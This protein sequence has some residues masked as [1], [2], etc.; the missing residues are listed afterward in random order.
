M[1]MGQIKSKNTV[2]LVLTLLVGMFFSSI[3]SAANFI[4]YPTAT[5]TD[6][7]YSLTWNTTGGTAEFHSLKVKEYLNDVFV[8][9][10][11]TTGT[12]IALI[13]RQ[14]GNYR[15][16]LQIVRR[17]WIPRDDTYYYLPA[18]VEDSIS[19]VVD[20]AVASPVID[21]SPSGISYDGSYVV[22]WNHVSFA[23]SY[24]LEE[25]IGTSAWIEIQNNGATSRSF[26][27]ISQGSYSYRVTACTNFGF[28]CSALSEI[29]TIDLA[30][31]PDFTYGSSTHNSINGDFDGNG[32]QDVFYQ[33]KNE[34]ITLGI[35][36]LNLVDTVNSNLHR[37]WTTT[38]PDFT[39]IEDWSEESYAAFSGNFNANA[40]DELLLLGRKSILL[41]HG[42]V[43]TP[44]TIFQP[45][46]NAIVSWNASNVA[47][48]TEF[49]FDAHPDNYEVI[50]GN[51]DGDEFDEIFLQ[52][53]SK[54]STSYILDSDGALIQTI[55]NGYRNMDWSAVSYSISITGGDIFLTALTS[56][57]DDNIA[58]T[59]ASGVITSLATV[60]TKPTISIT[61]NKYVFHNIA[62]NSIPTTTGSSSTFTY[63]AS[64]MPSWMSINT[65]TGELSGTPTINDVDQSH[66]IK[67]TVHENKTH[68][69]DVSMYV[70]INVVESFSISETGY[71]VYETTDGTLYLVSDNGVD[72]YKIVDD[73]G[74]D[75]V[76]K[77]S[78][79]EFNGA[80]ATLV[81]GYEVK[82]VDFNVDGRLDL[83]LTHPTDS[84]YS[85]ILI[86]D[87]YGTTHI[88]V[89][90]QF[91][92]VAPSPHVESIPAVD[93]NSQQVGAIQGNFRVDEGGAATYTIP[94]NLPTGT[95]GVTP[96]LALGYSS[97]GQN[98]IMG[99]GWTLSG[100]SSI[101]RCKKIPETDGL[102]TE[103]D[104]VSYNLTDKFC[105]DGHRLVLVSD[106]LAYG[107]NGAEYSTEI[108]S[109]QRVTSYGIAGNGP[110]YFIIESKDGAKTYYG[111]TVDSALKTNSS[112]GINDTKVSWS[113]NRS[114]DRLGNYINYVYFTDN[115]NG[116]QRIERIEYTGNETL[117]PYNFVHFDYESRDD[118]RTSYLNGSK[119][120]IDK[121]LAKIWIETPAPL[122]GIATLVKRYEFDYESNN[123]SSTNNQSLLAQIT[124]C[125]G[126]S[127]STCLQ[128]TSFD[129]EHGAN[130]F[131]G[132]TV[133]W[134]GGAFPASLDAKIK[135]VDP[136]D[137]NGDG[138]L[139]VAILYK[140]PSYGY[141]LQVGSLSEAGFNSTTWFKMP[142][143][144]G[145]LIAGH[146]GDI[147][148]DGKDDLLAPG[149]TYNEASWSYYIYNGTATGLQRGINTG[150]QYDENIKANQLMLAD[151]N[152]DALPD[153]VY[154]LSSS[155]IGIRRNLGGI[156]GIEEIK[157]LSFIN[158]DPNHELFK[159]DE[160][161]SLHD[162]QG[163]GRFDIIL[164]GRL[165]RVGW[166]IYPATCLDEA[167]NRRTIDQVFVATN[168]AE[169]NG[170]DFEFVSDLNVAFD[171]SDKTYIN[172]SGT[173]TP[174]GQGAAKFVD[175]N[176][177]GLVDI[178]HA[179][180]IHINRGDNKLTHPHSNHPDR[181]EQFTEIT[182]FNKSSM[183]DY[184][185]DGFL[186]V[187]YPDRNNS[188]HRWRVRLFDGNVFASEEITTNIYA[189][190]D[191]VDV[192]KSQHDIFSD[193]DGDSQIDRFYIAGEKVARI[194]AGE[195]I[196]AARNTITRF[197]NGM[198]NYEEVTYKP[199]TDVSVYKK[200]SG[201]KELDY[202]NGS[203]VFDLI[204]SY[205][206][207][208]EARSIAPDYLDEN[209]VVSVSY[210]YRNFRVQAGGRGSL[211]FEKIYS[212]D[213][214]TGIVTGTRYRQ[215]FPYI[216]SPAQTVIGY[217]MDAV[218]S[219]LT[220]QHLTPNEIISVTTTEWSLRQV[221]TGFTDF[222][223]LETS[224]FT[225]FIGGL[226][227][228][229]TTVLTVDDY[230]NVL[231][232][233]ESLYETRG[234]TPYFTQRKETINKY[235]ED[236]VTNWILGRLTETTVKTSRPDENQIVVPPISRTSSF[237]Y[238]SVS[239]QL[240]Y[241]I[242]N[243][244]DVENKLKLTT[245][246]TYDDFGNTLRATHC[247]GHIQPSNCGISTMQDEAD[248]YFINRYS[249]NEWDDRGR[250]VDRS[251][252]A[253][254]QK[255]TEVT[256]RHI[257]GLATQTVSLDGVVVD[258]AFDAHGRPYFERSSTGAWLLTQLGLITDSN[259]ESI[260]F[261]QTTNGAGVPQSTKQFDR[262][263][264]V[265]LEQ[266]IAFDGINVIYV[267][268]NYDSRGRLHFESVPSYNLAN[269]IGTTF[270][271]DDFGRPLSTIHPVGTSS[272][273]YGNE[274]SVTFTN[275]INQTKTEE[276]NALGE[277]IGTYENGNSNLKT[278]YGYDAVGNLTRT[279]DMD[280]VD[281]SLIDYD[282][283]GRKVEL[284]DSDM[285]I[286]IYDYNALGE[287]VEQTDAKLQITQI[288]YDQLGR[289][290]KRIETGGNP[291]ETQWFYDSYVLVD[292]P[293]KLIHEANITTGYSKTYTY[294]SF[295]RLNS[296]T[297][298]MPALG[299]VTAKSYVE[300]VTFDEY[301]RIF[302]KFDVSG[303]DA[304]LQ[305]VYDEQGY[306]ARIK[307]TRHSLDD[308]YYKINSMD[309]FGNLTELE[310]GNGITSNRDYDPATGMLD[311][312][313]T[314]DGNNIQDLGYHFDA[315][316]RLERR[317]SWTLEGGLKQE[318]FGY[319]NQ[320][321]LETAEILNSSLPILSLTY[322][323][324][325]N[326][327]TKSDVGT[328]I[329]DYSTNHSSCTFNSS[330]MH[331]VK[332][333]GTRSYCYDAN[334]NRVKTLENGSETQSVSYSNFNK[335]VSI[336][337][338]VNNHTTSFVYGV[339]RER[340]VRVDSKVSGTDTTHYVGNVEIHYKNNGQVEYKRSINGNASLS[341]IDGVSTLNY[342]FKDYQGSITAITDSQIGANAQVLQRMSFDPFG[343]R[344]VEI[345]WEQMN[346]AL[347][348]SFD[349]NITTRGYT[350]HEMLDEV[351]IIHMNGRTYD[352]EIGRFMQADPFVQDPSN[353]QN[354]NRYS[355]VLNSPMS[356]TDP[357]GY[358]Y[359]RVPV[360]PSTNYSGIL[361]QVGVAI[362]TYGASVPFQVSVAAVAGY[363]Q[364]G[365]LRGAATGAFT[366]YMMNHIGSNFSGGEKVFA[367]A[368]AGGIS[369]VLQGGKFGHGFVS[370][371]VVS[372]AHDTIKAIPSDTGQVLAAA[373]LGG[374]VSAATGGKFANGAVTSA[375]RW[376]FNE[377]AS[378]ST[379]SKSNNRPSLANL[380]A[381][382]K[383]KLDASILSVNEELKVRHHTFSSA[384]EAADF[385]HDRLGKLSDLYGVEIGANIYKGSL[386]NSAVVF[387]ATTQYYTNTVGLRARSGWSILADFHTHGSSE[388]S[389]LFS[390]FSDTDL[391][392]NIGGKYSGYLS[393]PDGN[394]YHFN[395]SALQN[396]G[397]A[398]TVS[399]ARKFVQ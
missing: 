169:P 69:L 110:N 243:P 208:A 232:I 93:I 97:A 81:A 30:Y 187:I 116:V 327:R 247:S 324:N 128:P 73:N 349:H 352:A 105:L 358:F 367:H 315:L 388:Y 144:E 75:V 342:L 61:S 80:S 250:F 53:K 285:G 158:E 231:T 199:L 137:F 299:S 29:K 9:D 337:N 271:Y 57:D 303:N 257:T 233:D 335:P 350:G 301:G 189:H 64:G 47:S 102:E 171:D 228:T 184:N 375:F 82:V 51:L 398:Q 254:E 270:S 353:G 390:G 140:R 200:G 238:D 142:S 229:K 329:Y 354:L 130:D 43:I 193:F 373:I 252:N 190:P 45:V 136:I 297:T 306:L 372:T 115:E 70:N 206:V 27:N 71:T 276:R 149:Y 214:L 202:G 368:V 267:S 334:G 153:L 341:I 173:P 109:I 377:G 274:F 289:K 147:D 58:Y 159:I 91:I 316:G 212:T 77:S 11:A 296:S 3:S 395:Y 181:I 13:N 10:V 326:I 156:F 346:E 201:A 197:N 161:S 177:D 260:G 90:D 129:W 268:R 263:G 151:V 150:I 35:L 338:T 165:C 287:L 244:D 277:L 111:N 216:G 347:L 68:T 387:N 305:Y 179:D 241:E 46:Q 223:Y 374:T 240:K 133:I 17:T 124:E 118:S 195:T 31:I 386:P 16:D 286:W 325:G 328:N 314:G 188:P 322:E 152:G 320:N 196:L 141:A 63:S 369:S 32:D 59:N 48:H 279:T 365:T 2:L 113:I 309:A 210:Q 227:Q 292:Y 282:L 392:G 25:R 123:E 234:G 262:L 76:L 12:S 275:Q 19:V 157:S 255:V 323:N 333:I 72:V 339:D 42:D 22:S 65:S 145:D 364:T 183:I 167:G 41:L 382:E 211:G 143:D 163:D 26:D 132:S 160:I 264:R 317:Q 318:E 92:D 182:N 180:S 148:G 245:A 205:Y 399:N 272:V 294:D 155:E 343:K 304:G 117:S 293:G 94:L 186:D 125:S 162:F 176:G 355:Y 52:A 154:L 281:T 37:S 107:A 242:V 139:D 62:Y 218:D 302:Q 138:L 215:D 253:L 220:S 261:N 191:D 174:P 265:V 83:F 20:I 311:T 100:L 219:Y 273:D 24:K 172:T 108:N 295:G 357:S 256:A 98:G 313:Q 85:E 366:V 185:G 127:D 370:S 308:Y 397:L 312:I 226:P 101:S 67:I 248:P 284:N 319:D 332:N 356:Y 119:F 18:T 60:V 269:N 383:S 56:A 86:D 237:H 298:D 363:A 266:T 246:Y 361:M 207:V 21:I 348:W 217:N 280:G 300:S 221:N 112:D 251:Y 378:V 278:T 87:I 360:K 291:T 34:G 393:A 381:E 5:N 170:I 166:D 222:P 146:V 84:A 126:E 345:N 55:N 74:V 4:S 89:F 7:N 122:S 54:G 389:V 88:V 380:T 359:Y 340:V 239:G 310:T 258:K 344:R 39:A 168:Q 44:I 225:Q 28:D 121:R 38:H 307:D 50:I 203:P 259:G 164:K 49:E 209:A 224:T 78:I 385:L 134:E 249:R 15:Y 283:L 351:G 204:N 213:T 106:N 290:I 8:G 330:S 396:S 288:Y 192:V 23:T 391:S 1:L 95:A 321:R 114:I 331:A 33:A 371:L 194:S 336:E 66:S 230:N 235:D 198:G 36:P 104:G 236:N 79:S 379:K 120:L 96:N 384:Q 178:L 99:K 14:S 103:M 394:L 6:G 362:M 131:Q 175:V 135:A 40:G 376:A